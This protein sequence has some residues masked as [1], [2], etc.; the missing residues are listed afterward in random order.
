MV[1][2]VS[3]CSAEDGRYTYAHSM[4]RTWMDGGDVVMVFN[5]NIYIIDIMG[6]LFCLFYLDEDEQRA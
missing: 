6:S 1:V 4:T 3:S 5:H 2:M